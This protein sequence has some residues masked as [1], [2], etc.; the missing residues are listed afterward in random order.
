MKGKDGATAPI[1]PNAGQSM[2]PGSELILPAAS[3][4]FYSYTF[5]LGVTH[6]A[7]ASSMAPHCLQ[8][9]FDKPLITP[10]NFGKTVSPTT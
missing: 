3:A 6:P 4:G 1:F 2:P 10:Q 9:Q 8:E 7:Q 5:S